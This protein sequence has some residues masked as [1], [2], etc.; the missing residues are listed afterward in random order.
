MKQQKIKK[1]RGGRIAVKIMLIIF[2]AAAVI[3]IYEDTHFRVNEYEIESSKLPAEFDGMKVLF[4][5]DLHSR[6][7]SPDNEPIISAIFDIDPDVILVGGDMF[8]SYDTDL[9][10]FPELVKGLSGKYPIYYTFGNHEAIAR[11]RDFLAVESYMSELEELGVV[12]LNDK[13]TA[14][15]RGGAEII[16]SGYDLE[17]WHYTK[18][19]ELKENSLDMKTA[20]LIATLGSC[21][22]DK[23]NI[24]LAHSPFFPDIYAEWG[25]DLVLSGHVHG[26]IIRLP[27]VGGLLSPEVSFF[28]EYD[29]GLYETNGSEMI[30]S[31][32][33]GNHGRFMRLNNMPE[34]VVATLR[35][36]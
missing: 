1:T 15:S 3:L 23:F 22:T 18:R 32:G 30:V 21:D 17:I 34:L 12:L 26:G 27:I 33:I 2:L 31:S 20:D 14:I 29:K 10:V 8:S 6:V 11:G 36:V 16:I 35:S 19:S 5:S 25:A 24:L 7:Y 13:S 9:S 28:P 4:I